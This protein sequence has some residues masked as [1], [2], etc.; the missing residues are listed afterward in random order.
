MYV[1]HLH[2]PDVNLFFIVNGMFLV[3]VFDFT[4]TLRL[5][6]PVPSMYGFIC[7]CKFCFIIKLLMYFSFLIPFIRC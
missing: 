4:V 1:L 6:V 5:L 7:Y 3:F 2:L